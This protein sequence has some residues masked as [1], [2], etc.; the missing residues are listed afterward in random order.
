[1]FIQKGGARSPDFLHVCTV[2]FGLFGQLR[3]LYIAQVSTC[4]CPKEAGQEVSR[5]T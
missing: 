1:M 3:I 2:D 5:R 4:K